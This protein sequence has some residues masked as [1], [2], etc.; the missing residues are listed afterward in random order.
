MKKL[1]CLMLALLFLLSSCSAVSFTMENGASSS[2]H[3]Q[4]SSLKVSENT[5]HAPGSTP[6]PTVGSEASKES[7]PVKAYP[8][9]PVAAEE[10][11]WLPASNT[12]HTAIEHLV[13]WNGLYVMEYFAQDTLKQQEHRKYYP[14]LV[15]ARDENDPSPTSYRTSQPFEHHSMEALSSELAA[16]NVPLVNMNDVYLMIFITEEEFSTLAQK[17]EHPEWFYFNHATDDLLPLFEG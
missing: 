8:L 1:F 17:L 13:Q 2:E 7:S 3:A 9:L 16:A 11:E 4:E 5:P 12:H 6:V 14:I 15:D 10:I